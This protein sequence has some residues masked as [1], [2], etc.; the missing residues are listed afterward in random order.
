MNGADLIF[1]AVEHRYTTPAGVVVPSVT[2]ILKRTG[3]ST[4]FEAL[5][6]R[7]AIARKRDI[8]TACH[9]DAHAYDD[10]DLDWTT[11]DPNVRPYLDAWVEF[12][13]VKRLTPTA[14]E[15]RVFHPSLG[16]CGTFDG[17]FE[18]PDLDTPVL[19][20]MKLGDPKDAAAQYQT[21][22]Y[23]LAHAIEAPEAMGYRRW[24]VQLLPGRRVPFLIT[25]YADWQ[26]FQVWQ[27]IVTTFFAQR[28][29]A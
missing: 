14:R 15:R 12:R 22:A 5:P 8:G 17:I 24:S 10:D 26:D 1:D 6:N 29:A 28:R 19:V 13:Q 16:Y 9:A 25:H 21:A 2:Q 23:V 11:V 7:D 3:V 20:D 4:D 27:A 18:S